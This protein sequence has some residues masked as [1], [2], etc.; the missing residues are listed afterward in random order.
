MSTRPVSLEIDQRENVTIF[1]LIF[2]DTGEI[3]QKRR[4]EEWIMKR[5]FQSE[6]KTL[7]KNRGD[8]L[9]CQE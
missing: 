5:V 1:N 6:I 4:S 9:D 8:V 3:R 2:H 7:F